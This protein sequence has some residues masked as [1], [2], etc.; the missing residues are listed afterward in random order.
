MK[1][2]N[3]VIAKKEENAYLKLRI[4]FLLSNTAV[5]MFVFIILLYH[6]RISIILYRYYMYVLKTKKKRRKKCTIKENEY[7]KKRVNTFPNERLKLFKIIN[8]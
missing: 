1:Y 8:S 5:T 2:H 3:C 4:V 6:G 7:I